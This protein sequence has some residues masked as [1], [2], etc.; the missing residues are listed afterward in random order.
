MTSLAN[1]DQNIKDQKAKE[2]VEVSSS[3]K[4][5]SN[6]VLNLLN[7]FIKIFKDSVIWFARGLS[8]CIS[9]VLGFMLVTIAIL[10]V[11]TALSGGLNEVNSDI[12]S[13]NNNKEIF[14]DYGGQEEIA[15]IELDGIIYENDAVAE[16]FGGGMST[17]TPNK[18]ENAL[19]KVREDSQ[20]KAVL[21]YLNSPGGS[22]VASDR[23]YE[24]IQDFKTDT[25]APVVVLMGDIAASGGYY[26]SAA[27][28]KIYAH[29]S[30]IT[31][32][33]G[34]IMET[35]N[36]KGLYEKIG[37]QKQV[38]KAGKYKDILND[39]RDMTQE[40]KDIMNNLMSD[41]YNS[42]LNRV[43]EG[44]GMSL[45]D[46]RT[47]A[48]GK[49]YSGKS[50]KEAGLVDETG[51]LNDAI[52]ATAKLS[53][54]EKYKVVKIKGFSFFDNLLLGLE[55]SAGR[56]GINLGVNIGAVNQPTYRIL[57]KLP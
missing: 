32:S 17:I 54:L 52:K 48:E 2:D 9:Q 55:S 14:R 30:T 42:F 41:A 22:P 33:I 13:V 56:L 8:S 16:P 20:I 3:Q 47:K 7:F 40:E 19:N 45:E 12:A 15:L 23:I 35:Y 36:L 53:N 44:R 11:I 50:A 39:S 29:P 38:F 21:I 24:I 51:T 27:A 6:V 46:V 10:L 25:K 31:G 26:I 28:N 57:Y 4:T 49:I 43:S 1:E 5:H 34:V 37:V 18:V